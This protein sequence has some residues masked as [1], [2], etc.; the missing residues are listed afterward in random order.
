MRLRRREEKRETSP[1]TRGVCEK[2][3]SAKKGR[4]AEMKKNEKCEDS[5]T[6]WKVEDAYTKEGHEGTWGGGKKKILKEKETDKFLKN[7]ERIA[8]AALEK[9]Q[10]GGI[11]GGD[12]C[13][14][15]KPQLK[16]ETLLGKKK[17][18][19]GKK[20]AF[21]GGKAELIVLVKTQS[22]KENQRPQ[23]FGI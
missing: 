4:F 6:R 16:A 9:V 11:R 7:E 12:A 10:M 14:R 23:N 18:I 19:T 5:A 21:K 8:R 22:R 17:K 2:K 20:K 1:A 3:G 13:C 15:G